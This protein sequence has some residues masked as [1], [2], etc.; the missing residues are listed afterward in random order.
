MVII[1]NIFCFLLSCVVVKTVGATAGATA[2]ALSLD[3]SC[4]SLFDHREQYGNGNDTQQQQQVLLSLN[5]TR[6]CYRKRGGG[7][8][9]HSRGVSNPASGPEGREIDYTSTQA[10]GIEATYSNI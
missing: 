3:N 2:A 6:R 7:R 8:K 1:S 10:G 5:K 9:G 4:I